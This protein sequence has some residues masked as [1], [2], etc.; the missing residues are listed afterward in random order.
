MKIFDERL[1]NNRLRYVIQSLL[2]TGVVLVILVVLEA[3]ESPAVIAALGASAFVVFAMPHARV[4]RSRYLIGGYAVGLACGTL[5]HHLALLGQLAEVPFVQDHAYIIF[6][7]AAVGL[8]IFVM[9]ITNT[10][11]PP[12]SALALGLVLGEWSVMTV[13]VI[14][15]GIL[16]LVLMNR[17]LRPLLKD[18]IE[19]PGEPLPQ[20][21]SVAEIVKETVE[22]PRGEPIEVSADSVPREVSP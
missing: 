15:V 3:L 22:H 21:E 13:L 16:S 2:A 8:A 9:T 19:T 1:K 5:C 12:A 10:E 17:V 6:G 20:C 7:A 11:H 18:L 4:S 14:I